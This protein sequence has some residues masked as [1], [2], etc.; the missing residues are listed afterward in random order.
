M[1]EFME[2]LNKKTTKLLAKA[3]ELK[4]SI[5]K[6]QAELRE[7]NFKIAKEIALGESAEYLG[8]KFSNKVNSTRKALDQKALKE[9]HPTIYA[10]FVKETETKGGISITRPRL[11]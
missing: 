4:V 2:K 9:A 6:D 5:E 3:M 10:E 1:E 8:W 7:I 11:K